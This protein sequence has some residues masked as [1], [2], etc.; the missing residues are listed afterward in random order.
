LPAALNARMWHFIMSE[1][2]IPTDRDLMLAVAD[3]DD[4]AMLESPCR[5]VDGRWIATRTGHLVD[6]HPTHWR[7][8]AQEKI[9]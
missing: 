5:W 9:R 1:N 8:W 6:V 2:A 4:F 3:G 7:E